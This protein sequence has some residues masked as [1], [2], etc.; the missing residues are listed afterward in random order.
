VNIVELS[1]GDAD[2]IGGIGDGKDFVGYVLWEGG[3]LEVVMSG[4]IC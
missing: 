4:L 2:L 3:G 1:P